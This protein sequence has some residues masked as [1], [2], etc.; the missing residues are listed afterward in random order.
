M[1][2]ALK[3]GRLVD[4]AN[5]LNGSHDLFIDNGKIVALNHQPEG[6]RPDKEINASGLHIIPGII[7]LCA[8][9]REPG[10]EH[11]ATIASETAAA[12]SGGIT[13]MVYPP[14]PTPTR[15]SILQRWQE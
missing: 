2:I 9:L 8:R 14:P 13:R 6:F 3:N 4:P 11:K 1:K 5:G 7:D 15:L 12:A 10:E